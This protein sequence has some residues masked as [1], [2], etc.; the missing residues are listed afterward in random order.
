MSDPT[1]L[2]IRLRKARKPRMCSHCPIA[3]QKDQNYYYVIRP[4]QIVDGKGLLQQT[5]TQFWQDS[6]HV[7]CW[8]EVNKPTTTVEGGESNTTTEVK[9]TL[10]DYIQQEVGRY[11]CCMYVK[12]HEGEHLLHWERF[13]T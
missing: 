1:S 8:E 5:S 4:V 6:Y 11:G 9:I 7:K 3:I 12:G 2:K 10:C 13:L